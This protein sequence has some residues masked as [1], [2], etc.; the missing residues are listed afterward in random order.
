MGPLET[1]KAVLVT[2]YLDDHQ[3]LVVLLAAD[4]S[5]NRLGFGRANESERDLL[6]GVTKEPLF[7]ELMTHSRAE[8]V[9]LL[10]RG[11]VLP[12]GREEDILGIHCKLTVAFQFEES[13]GRFEFE[14]GSESGVLPLDIR[15]FVEKAVEITNPWMQAHRVAVPSSVVTTPAT[16]RPWWRFW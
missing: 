11:F 3:S 2:L 6:I 10:N 9:S 4:G 15:G 1:A 12:S 5:I 13:W 16:R 8:W 14:Y 7:S